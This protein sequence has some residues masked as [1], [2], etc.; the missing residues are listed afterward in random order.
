MVWAVDGDR[1]IQLGACFGTVW[2]S[3]LQLFEQMKEEDN[4]SALKPTPRAKE[5]LTR[6]RGITQEKFTPVKAQETGI[7]QAV[8]DEKLG[9]DVI[10]SPKLLPPYV[11]AFFE[12]AETNPPSITFIISNGYALYNVRVRGSN[13][14]IGE[15]LTEAKN[16]PMLLDHIKPYLYLELPNRKGELDVR[17]SVTDYHLKNGDVLRVTSSVR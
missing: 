9:E 1:A 12:R 8:K 14:M 16:V 15:V 5:I 17:K 11:R 13:P 7:V 6:L 10:L 4:E 3:P 2:L